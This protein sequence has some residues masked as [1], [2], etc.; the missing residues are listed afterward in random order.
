MDST[1][2]SQL[3]LR[4]LLEARDL[5]HAHLLNKRN[6][7]STAIGRYLIRRDDPW[8]TREVPSPPRPRGP[9]P[10]RKLSDSQV[11]PYSWP[12]ILVFVSKWEE[13]AALVNDGRSDLVP[14]AIYMP[15]GRVVPVCTVLAPRLDKSFDVVDKNRLIFPRNVVSGGYPVLTTVQGSDRV[16][17]IGCLVTDANKVYAITNRHVVGTSGTPLFTLLGGQVTRLGIS[18]KNQLGKIA[19]TDAYPGWPGKNIV[20]NADIGLIEVDSVDMWKTEVFGIGKFGDLLDLTVFN[21]SLDLID[22]V[23]NPQVVHAFGAVSGAL[24]GVIRALFYR[25]KSVGGREYVSDFLIGPMPGSKVITHHGDSGTLWLLKTN[26]GSRPFAVQWGAHEFLADG[27]IQVNHFAL[28]TCLSTVCRELDVDLIRGWNVDL[29]YTWGKTGHFKVAARACELVSDSKL[30]T[31]MMANQRNIGYV[32]DD[33]LKDQVV[34][35]TFT[36]DFVPLA[37][38]ADIIWRTTR[39]DDESNHFADIDEADSRVFGGKT[40]LELSI[41]DD[42][43]FDIDFWIDFDR[44]MDVIDPKTHKNR[45]TGKVEPRPRAGALPFRVRQMYLQMIKSLTAGK[46]AEFVCAAGT[47]AHYVGDACQ[48]LHVSY[49]HH[50][51]DESESAVHSDYETALIE[52]KM[53]ELFDGVN[54]VANKVDVTELISGNGKDAARLVL[55]LMKKTIERLPPIDVV[56]ACVANRG[57]GRWDKIWDVVGDQTIQNIANGCHTLAVLWQSAWK[58]GNGHTVAT[59]S[60]I[61]FDHSTLSDL[62]S[63]KTFVPSY[64]LQDPKFKATLL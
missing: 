35:G 21:I 39:P 42:S 43:R 40:L 51:R 14:K 7:V 10:E 16:A 62:Y 4:D 20:V 1:K 47:M 3:S 13:D 17:S 58:A 18:S 59:G 28:A 6:V 46:V 45:K 60:L 36:H 11:R 34:P 38:V 55:Q 61:E 5:Y 15:D 53:T 9:R 48:P 26:E 23:D 8:P 25:Y 64:V 24:N 33:L 57:R 63:Q 56:E 29:G 27:E 32:D 22:S 19:F 37:D 31:L 30:S 2:Y 12:C 49:L 52:K 50:G 41:A 54:A 44:Q